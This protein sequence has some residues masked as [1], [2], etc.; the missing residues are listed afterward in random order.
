MLKTGI[1]DVLGESSLLLPELVNRA[2]A[3]NDR[4]KYYFTLLQAAKAHADNPEAPAADLSSE[5]V[6]CGVGDATLDLV[7]GAST[8]AGDGWYDIPQAGRLHDLIVGEM[9]DMLAPLEYAERADGYRLRLKGLLAKLPPASGDS[10][11]SD[12]IAAVTHGRSAGGDS[13]HLLVMDLHK[14]L[15]ALQAGLAQESVDGAHAY[16]L[17]AGDRDRVRAFMAGLNETAPLKF[18]HPGLGTTATR[19]GDKLVIQNDIGTTDAHVLVVHVC[20]L[21]VTMTYTDVHL[22]RARFFQSLFE[23]FGVRWED[24]HTR[25]SDALEEG[26]AFYLCRSHFTGRDEDELDRYLAFL[27]SRIVFLIDWNRARKRLRNFLKMRDGIAVLKWAADHNV[28]HRG[29]LQLGG[30]RLVYEAIE[31]AA[32]TPIRYGERLDELLGR[33]LAV[34]YLKFVLRTAAKG[35][36][37][38]RSERLIRDEIRAELVSYFHTTQEGLREIAADHAALI[39][40]LANAVRDGLAD[41]VT[42]SP[43]DELERV[44]ARA[45]RWETRADELLTRAR[46]MV[47]I[48]GTGSSIYR[49]LIEEADDIADNLEDVTFRLPLIPV[50]GAANGRCEPLQNL[51]DLLVAGAQDYVRCLEVLG[52]VHRG[53]SREDVQEFLESVD[54]I[55]TVEHRTDEEERALTAL[56][57]RLAADFREFELL[58]GVGQSLEMAADSLCRC[59]LML[60]DHVLS[61]VMVG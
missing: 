48:K 50:V 41:A 53:S 14:A 59:A 8:C 24:T 60:R 52:A 61:E 57:M 21:Q 58:S 17:G 15:N 22:R 47:R 46:D 6:A 54:C 29:F 25:R 5:R 16:N 37:E 28:G 31:Y 33:D 27:G 42:G 39:V 30:E 3:A 26:E 34:E 2:L 11:D 38:G 23:P 40:D 36:R 9:E 18:D 49:T 19:A 44:S 51:S 20:G 4:V 55:V 56:L 13:L 35:L 1:I 10:V 32:R 7:V 45:K 12:Y 43:Q